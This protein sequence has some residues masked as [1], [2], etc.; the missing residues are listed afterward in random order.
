VVV[1]FL[2]LNR[3]I[4][5]SLS[6]LVFSGHCKKLK[7]E[8]QKA[9][10]AMHGMVLFAY[11]PSEKTTDATLGRFGVKGFPTIWVW[12]NGVHEPYRGERTTEALIA[13]ARTLLI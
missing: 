6:R 8:F 13:F 7:P 2:C 5:D 4:E 1:R 3:F 10:E 11:C 12:K 9:A